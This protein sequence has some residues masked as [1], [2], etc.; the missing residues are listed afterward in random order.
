MTRKPRYC[1]ISI[2]G[3]FLVR[4]FLNFMNRLK[5]KSVIAVMVTVSLSVGLWFGATRC[6]RTDVLMPDMMPWTS[7][8]GCGSGAGGPSSDVQLKWIGEGIQGALFDAEIG[9]GRSVLA[10]TSPLYGNKYDGRL[11]LQTTTI[12]LNAYWHPPKIMDIK[13]A[14]P[15]VLK[16]GNANN[17]NTGPFSD[18]SLELSRKWGLVGNILTAVTVVFPTG[19]TSLTEGTVQPLSSDNLLGGGVFGTSVRTSYTFDH[20]WG[21]VCL[22]GSYSAGLFALITS[23]YDMT[24]S[25]TF[26]IDNGAYDTAYA[27][28]SGRKT[29]KFSR[30]GWGSI[31]DAG[32]VTPDFIGLFADIGIKSEAVTHGFSVNLGV[33][34]RQGRSELRQVIPTNDAFATREEAR[35]YLDTL[36]AANRGDTT[37]LLLQQKPNGTWNTMRKVSVA[38]PVPPSLMIQY[39]VE[40]HDMILPMLVG[41]TIKL[42]NPTIDLTKFNF[43]KL[44]FA[45]FSIGLG[46]KFPIY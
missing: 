15:L 14:L 9:V 12:S 21:I 11:R 27:I 40:K 45:G 6:R 8:G 1:I 46:F 17:L 34:M 19:N 44:V 31:N 43:G 3:I 33:P 30:N 35:F 38:K 4:F 5:M 2:I 36:Q 41:G 25:Y 28:S 32:I 22:G 24:P 23:R 39:S 42:E 10:D 26:N 29:L 18:L 16:E 37:N 20:D 13:V 7:I